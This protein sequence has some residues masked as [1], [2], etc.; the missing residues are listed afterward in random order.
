MQKQQQHQQKKERSEKYTVGNLP[1]NQAFYYF[2]NKMFTNKCDFLCIYQLLAA[3]I[4]LDNVSYF[5]AKINLDDYFQLIQLNCDTQ[6]V[7]AQNTVFSRSNEWM[8]RQF[9]R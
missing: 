1:I 6:I 9:F 2:H 7:A 3:I 4:T 8:T 5:V